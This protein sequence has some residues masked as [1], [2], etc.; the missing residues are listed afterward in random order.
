MEMIT[1]P[2]RW[3]I[4]VLLAYEVWKLK[5]VPGHLDE[6]RLVSVVFLPHLCAVPRHVVTSEPPSGMHF[7]PLPAAHRAA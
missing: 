2:L 7:P 1:P 3:K 6:A 5:G 4:W